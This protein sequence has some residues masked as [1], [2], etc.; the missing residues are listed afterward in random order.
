MCAGGS[1][2]KLHSQL[3]SLQANKSVQLGYLQ[4]NYDRHKSR[5]KIAHRLFHHIFFS[6][7]DFLKSIRKL[8]FNRFNWNKNLIFWLFYRKS[9]RFFFWFCGYQNNKNLIVF[10]RLIKF[11]IINFAKQLNK[12]KLWVHLPCWAK[13][14]YQK[15]D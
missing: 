5:W 6:S 14:K 8:N 2:N 13:N 4:T 12:I 10:L 1:L 7:F 9:V 15:K 3:N 11:H